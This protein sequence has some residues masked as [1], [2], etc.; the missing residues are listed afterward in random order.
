MCVAPLALGPFSASLF[1]VGVISYLMIY[2][3]MLI[4]DL[5]NSFGYYD[6]HSGEQ[7]SLK[8]LED[9]PFQIEHLVERETASLQRRD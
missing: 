4:R 3:L 7:V 5:D 9:R 2:L 1:F 8:P 6:R